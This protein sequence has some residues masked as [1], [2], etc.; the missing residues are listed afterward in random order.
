M[1]LY[2]L[3]SRL[4]L[5]KIKF[6][7]CRCCNIVNN[8]NI[9][10]WKCGLSCR[11]LYILNINRIHMKDSKENNGTEHFVEFGPVDSTPR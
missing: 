7:F 1:T 11:Y 8:K 4:H 10:V 9:D 6:C 3:Y 5:I 2:D